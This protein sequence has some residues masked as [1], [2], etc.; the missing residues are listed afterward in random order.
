VTVQ[1]EKP[2]NVIVQRYDA[3][4]VRLT[5]NGQCD[6]QIAVRD[7]DFRVEPGA[8]YSADAE[9][10]KNAVADQKGTVWFRL[11]LSG[12]RSVSIRTV[13]RQ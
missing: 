1:A 6:I 5:L 11:R 4:G 3:Q 7:G 9:T 8:T 13:Q 10:P 12:Q 2:V